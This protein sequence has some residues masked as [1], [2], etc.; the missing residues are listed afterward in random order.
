[1]EHWGGCYNPWSAFIAAARFAA[2]KATSSTSTSVVE[3]LYKDAMAQVLDYP[4]QAGQG[5]GP[6]QKTCL[7]TALCGCLWW[8]L[9]ILQVTIMR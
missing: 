7:D 4:D 9:E 1:M 5:R 2:S 3:G 8:M 6:L